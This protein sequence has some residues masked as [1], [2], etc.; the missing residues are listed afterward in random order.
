M[1]IALENI[2]KSFGSDLIFREVSARVEDRDRIGLVGINGAG[3]TTLLNIITGGLEPDEGTVTR[4]SSL[5]IGYQRQNAGL[6]KGN[7][8]LE[9]SLNA[10]FARNAKNITFSNL[11]VTVDE[12]MKEYMEQPF[13]ISDCE[14]L[15]LP[16]R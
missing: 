10:V 1:Q 3:K 16:N 15:C 4:G 11:K 7:T 13:D 9:G 2:G 12:D 6:Q 5:S 8:I 14:T